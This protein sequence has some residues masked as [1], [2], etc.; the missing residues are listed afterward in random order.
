M[1]TM[2]KL[3]NSAVTKFKFCTQKLKCCSKQTTQNSALTKGKFC[4]QEMEIWALKMEIMFSE[5]GKFPQ[6]HE[7]SAFR[8][9]LYQI[10]Q[11]RTILCCRA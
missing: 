8:D 10:S 6:C 4:A 9:F 11:L 3:E 1:Q 5:S 7:K 2:L